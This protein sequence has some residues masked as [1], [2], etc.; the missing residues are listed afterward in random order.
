MAK[1]GKAE[2]KEGKAEA[3]KGKA[4]AK[5][6]K[7]EAKKGKAKVKCSLKTQKKKRNKVAITSQKYGQN[8]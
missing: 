1:K 3:K 8:N 4:E 2:A 5:E 6:G 7:A